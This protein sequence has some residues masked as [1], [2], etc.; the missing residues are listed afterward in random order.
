MLGTELG[1]R[2][3]RD[4]IAKRT[5][6]ADQSS[7]ANRFQNRAR[8]SAPREARAGRRG[9]RGAANS[10]ISENRIPSVESRRKSVVAVFVLAVLQTFIL[11]SQPLWFRFLFSTLGLAINTENVQFLSTVLTIGSLLLEPVATFLVMYAIGLTA[12]LGSAPTSYLS[13]LLVGALAGTFGCVAAM[14][15]Y[16]IHIGEGSILGGSYLAS[17]TSYG[18]GAFRMAL[19]AFAG[20]ALAHFTRPMRPGGSRPISNR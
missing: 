6:N 15:V 4:P 12:D 20:L 14:T 13:G 11:V 3:V 18:I 9:Q 19:V 5:L 7:S 17:L 2:S 10:Y 16:Y 1:R 8:K